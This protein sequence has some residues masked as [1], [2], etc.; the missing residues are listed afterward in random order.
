MNTF[1]LR[2][3]TDPNRLK[4]GVLSVADDKENLIPV[5]AKPP[6][7]LAQA[8]HIGKIG[9]IVLVGLSASILSLAATPGITLPAWLVAV[10]TAIGAAGGA[11]GIASGGVKPPKGEPD[12]LK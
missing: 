3:R 1:N 2:N 12:E 5:V 11:I 6:T 7:L 8:L 10:A 9:A 4:T